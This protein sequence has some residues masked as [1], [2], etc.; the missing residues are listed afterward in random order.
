VIDSGKPE[1]EQ[2]D[3]LVRGVLG[4]DPDSGSIAVSASVR[5]GQVLRLHARDAQSADE[6][7]RRALGLHFEAMGDRPAAGAI[8]FSCNGRGSSMFGVPDHDASAV[9][10]ELRGAPAAGFFA[11]GEIGPVG[12]RSFL[13]SFTATVAV[14]PD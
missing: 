2:G 12:G 1:Y 3:F 14:F 8:V 13:H 4:A 7:L 9:H 10:Y 6:D 11:A 5:P